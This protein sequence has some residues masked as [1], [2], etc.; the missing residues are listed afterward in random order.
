GRP[1]E[2]SINEGSL[3]NPRGVMS[4]GLLWSMET[5]E[6]QLSS[7][8]RCHSLDHAGWARGSGSLSSSP[9]RA[10]PD[11]VVAVVVTLAVT[12]VPRDAGQRGRPRSRTKWHRD[13]QARRAS[14]GLL[15]HAG[16][17]A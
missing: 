2:S 9:I 1:A 13:D 14:R 5:A 8:S 10:H 17:A 12:V 6:C 3:T 16:P 15:P 11:V 4:F 7:R